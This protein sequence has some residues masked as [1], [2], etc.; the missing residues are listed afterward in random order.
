MTHE[1]LRQLVEM[2]EAIWDAW[3]PALLALE[4]EAARRAVG[5]SFPSVLATTAHMVS[6]EIAWQDRFEGR[7]SLGA[8]WADLAEVHRHWERLRA[9]RAAWLEGADP[10]ATV[11]YTNARGEAFE[12]TVGEI[13]FV[14]VTHAHFHRGQLATQFRL[15][16]R[17]PPSAHFLRFVARPQPG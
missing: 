14:L 12:S 2:H 9:R 5:G 8:A 16:G 6:Q 15:L 4:P 3:W 7:R 17:T 11:R 13:W 10:A 1:T